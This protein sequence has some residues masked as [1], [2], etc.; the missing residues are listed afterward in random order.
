MSVN[1]PSPQVTQVAAEVAPRAAEN[2]PIG[3]DVHVPCVVAPT[4]EE[5]LPAAHR[6]HAADPGPS[7]YVPWS[8]ER[9]AARV[10]AEVMFEYVPMGHSWHVDA[11]VAARAAEYLP[12]GHESHAL[13]PVCAMNFPAGHCRHCELPSWSA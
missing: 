10:A 12:V 1:L 4:A 13:A 8:H 11:E 9:Q 6:E 2:F 7:A 3:Q 5:N